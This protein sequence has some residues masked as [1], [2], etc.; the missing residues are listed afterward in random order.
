MIPSW[1]LRQLCGGAAV[2]AWLVLLGVFVVLVGRRWP[3]QGEWSRKLAHIGA[4]PLVLIAWGLG[5]DR[6]V[7]VPAALVMTLAAAINHRRRLLPGIEDVDRHSYGTIAYG[8]SFSLLLLLWWPAHRA[9][10][11]AAILV[12]ALG[13]GLAGLL[14]RLLPSPSWQVFRQRR[15]VVGTITM[16]VSSLLVLLAMAALAQA[17]GQEAVPAMGALVGI[18]LAAVLVEQLAFAGLDN[19]TVPLSVGWLWIWAA[20]GG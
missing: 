10:V 2:A 4:G 9:A 11:A 14:G 1:W 3:D 5:I 20:Y 15:S 12:M 19:L 17:S 7:A 16:G 18:A 6:L 8:A 13:D